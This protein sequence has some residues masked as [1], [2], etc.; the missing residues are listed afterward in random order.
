[1]CIEW[2][3]LKGHVTPHAKLVNEAAALTDPS[4]ARLAARDDFLPASTSLL[5]TH[6]QA[7]ARVTKLLESGVTIAGGPDAVIAR[8]LI[9]EAMAATP[10][11]EF[12]TASPAASVPPPPAVSLLSL[13]PPKDASAPRP[14]PEDPSQPLRLVPAPPK[15]RKAADIAREALALGLGRSTTVTIAEPPPFEAAKAIDPADVAALE[16]AHPEVTLYSEELGGSVTLVS[17]PTNQDRLEMTFRDAATLRLLVDAFP[18][19]R[20]IALARKK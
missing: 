19:A 9:D 5:E 3:K 7:R 11:D 13:P 1:M 2:L 12:L 6:E 16:A 4:G 17:A 20:V 14:P 10:G 18:G 8:T 15:P